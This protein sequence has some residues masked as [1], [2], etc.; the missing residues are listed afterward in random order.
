MPAVGNRIEGFQDEEPEGDVEKSQTDDDKAHHRAAAEG[1]PETGVERF[2]GGLSRA[3]R[4]VGGRFHA[5]ESGQSGKE[6]AAQEGHRN[7]GILDFEDKGQ[8]GQNERQEE[9]DDHDDLVL[10]LEVGHGAFADM[11]SDPSHALVAFGRF[12]HLTVKIKSERERQSRAHR[13]QPEHQVGHLH[14]SLRFE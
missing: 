1:D 13:R 2:A 11:E 3:G 14:F 6:S 8:N 10:L 5:E 7:P 4:G 12:F 9:K